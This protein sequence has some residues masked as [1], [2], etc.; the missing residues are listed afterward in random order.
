MDHRDDTKDEE[1]ESSPEEAKDAESRESDEEESDDEDR[2]SPAAPPPK[3]EARSSK[4]SKLGRLAREQRENKARAREEQKQAAARQ[5]LIRTIGAAVL[6][7]AAGLAI[8]WFGHDARAKAKLRSESSP[9]AAGSGGPCDVWQEKICVNSG[10]RS[11]ACQQAKGATEL[12]TPGTC[13]TALGSV[14]A[15][16]EKIKAARASCDTLVNKLCTDLPQGSAACQM[17]KER[18]SSFPADRCKGM[19]DEYPQVLAQLKMLDEQGGMMGR[20]QMAPPGAPPGAHAPPGGM[21][22]GAPPGA[23]PQGE[24][25]P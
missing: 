9:A 20:P 10:D 11:A 14:P 4:G 21:P 24:P 15:T 12:M 1:R 2:D 6:A 22:R 3:S 8:G 18:A 25:H 23:V 19:L 5:V 13:E 7:L 16:L 17:V